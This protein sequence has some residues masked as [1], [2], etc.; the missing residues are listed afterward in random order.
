MDQKQRQDVIL[1][2]LD[3]AWEIDAL[4][5]MNVL[6]VDTTTV[7]DD[8]RR[9]I[10][11]GDMMLTAPGKYWKPFNRE[12][13]FNI[14][15]QDREKKEYDENILDNY[16]PLKSSFLTDS[17]IHTLE[18]K[19]GSTSYS[20]QENFDFMERFYLSLSYYSNRLS[21]GEI[22][23]LDSEIFLKYNHNPKGQLFIH[24]Q[25]ILNYKHML[26]DI[27]KHPYD[28]DFTILDFQKFHW[29]LM[30]KR[31]TE[32]LYGEIRDFDLVIPATTY[33]PV[34]NIRTLENIFNLFI[35]KLQKIENPFEK[36]FFI[37]VML[38]YILPFSKGNLELSRIM[39]NIPLIQWNCPPLLF[40][41]TNRLEYDM[42][43]RVFY[44]LHDMS[45][46]RKIFLE[47]MSHDN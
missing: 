4:T 7:T 43:Y 41:K 8:F 36:S 27:I 42:A 40:E 46:L 39:A 26:D 17:V 14:P 30:N 20:F 1:Q 11:S 6:D 13:Y 9:L 5:V 29:L 45:L 23:K 12:D 16:D 28:V 21:G 38:P 32:T 15:L 3:T 44:E 2:L 34:K 10:A 22:K 47:A 18:K 37:F 24:C 25:R 35:T 19:E 31:I 33:R